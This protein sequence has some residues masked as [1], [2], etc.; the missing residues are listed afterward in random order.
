MDLSHSRHH[1]PARLAALV[2][3][4]DKTPVWVAIGEG[5]CRMVRG[6]LGRGVYGTLRRSAMNFPSH[7]R[8]K[9]AY[10]LLAA[11]VLKIRGV[12]DSNCQFTLLSATGTALRPVVCPKHWF[13]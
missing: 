7:R 6:F 12:Y 2:L 5:W 4:E 9:E 10:F 13:P 11:G 3:R 1:L 8:E